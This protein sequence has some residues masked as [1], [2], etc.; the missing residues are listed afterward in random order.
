MD[1]F[2]QLFVSYDTIP[3]LTHVTY[4]LEVRSFQPHARGPFRARSGFPN[5]ESIELNTQKKSLTQ[6]A[7]HVLFP[8]D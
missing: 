6:F 5:R 8:H 2:R 1:K 7:S 4:T 3:N